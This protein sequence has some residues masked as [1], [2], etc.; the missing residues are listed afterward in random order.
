MRS[1]LAFD[2]ETI[3]DA[4][5]IRT[6]YQLP[7]TLSDEDTVEFMQQK[8]RA[9]AN[10]DFM[11]LH[12]QKVVAISCCMRRGEKNIKIAT[13]G[14][15]EDSE[16]IIIL[17]FFDLIEQCTPQLVS[18]NGNGFDLPVLHYRGL[19][20]GITA[21][22][23]WDMGDS[24]FYDSKD[25][26]WNNYVSRYHARHCDLMDLLALYQPKNNIPLDEISKLCS[27]PG[28]MGMDGSKV[29]NAYQ[30]GKIEEIRDYCETDALNTYL[31]FLRF[32]LMRGHLDADEYHREIEIVRQFLQENSDKIHFTEFQNA[33][34]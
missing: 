9:D 33:W 14:D 18:W 1:I 22:R 12:L 5:G 30:A 19:I 34:I 20:H 28:K 6:L 2:I 16:D 17:K 26:K 7:T 15:K 10:S 27:F 3:P 11:P 13:L 23:Y 8:R 29:W 24:D 32:E 25:F 21:K 4:H 31:M